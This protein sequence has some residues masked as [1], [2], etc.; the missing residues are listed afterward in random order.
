[1]YNLAGIIYFVSFPYLS[2]DTGLKI[3]LSQ[4]L[5]ALLVAWYQW[6]RFCFAS[7]HSK[8]SHVSTWVIPSARTE[9]SFTHWCHQST[10]N[11]PFVSNIN[12][13]VRESYIQSVWAKKKLLYWVLLA[14]FCLWCTVPWPQDNQGSTV[15]DLGDPIGTS[16]TGT[17]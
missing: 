1:M 2:A 12:I 7:S 5:T 17:Q 11:F 8:E 6:V 10:G 14:L 9:F 15:R 16:S 4:F 3:K 13:R